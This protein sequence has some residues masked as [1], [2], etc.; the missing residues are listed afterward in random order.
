MRRPVWLFAALIVTSLTAP[1][2]AKVSEAKLRAHIETLASDEF[3]GREPGTEG[4]RKTTSY[5]VDAWTKAGLK[6]GA[7]DGFS[8]WASASSRDMR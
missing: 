3:E 2:L 7:R 6:P 1:A 4:E 5:I 8:P